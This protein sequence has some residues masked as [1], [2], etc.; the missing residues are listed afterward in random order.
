MRI[1]FVNRKGTYSRSMDLESEV[2]INVGQDGSALISLSDG[3]CNERL[4][5]PEQTEQ[6]IEDL[7]A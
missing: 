3:Y 4:L 2:T 1:Q 5:T 6:A 7:E